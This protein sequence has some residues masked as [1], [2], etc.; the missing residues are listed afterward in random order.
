M[1]RGGVTTEAD[2]AFA[3]GCALGLLDG[4][5]RSDPIWAG[6]WRQ[7]LTLKCAVSAVK[8]LGWNEEEAALRDAVL[9]TSPGD[10]PGP[11]G[12]VLVAYRR[13]AG[14]TRVIDTKTLRE[15]CTLLSVGWDE[16]LADIPSLVDD[17]LQANRAA[18]FIVADLATRIVTLRPDAEVL[19]WWLADWVL[20]QKLRWP[21]PVP[22]LMA[23]RYGPA[24]RTIGGRGRMLP[25]DD[26]F[27]RAVCIALAQ[28]TSEALRM[29]G[30][31]E[32]RAD[33]MLKVSGKVRTKGASA[34]I[35][36]LLDDDAVV[37]SAPGTN[38]SRWASRRLFERLESLGGVREL[39]GRQS[40]R[41]FG[42]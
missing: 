13:L 6:C 11:A 36:Q 39:S 14:G 29:A 25:G 24:F 42:L 2:A 5:V 21:R 15:L 4:L 40:F 20:A 38:L 26:G 12:S 34:V 32:R 8:L 28:G 41:I 22:L 9:L 7:R 18:P 37:V 19:A 10:S 27:H 30:E 16:L 33:H 31:I 3:A 1:P 17:L 23:E 35:R